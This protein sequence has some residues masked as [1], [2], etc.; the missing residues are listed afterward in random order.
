[1]YRFIFLLFL[2]G[3]NFS[4]KKVETIA[5]AL[6]NKFQVSDIYI[7]FNQ[8][9]TVGDLKLINGKHFFFVNKSEEIFGLESNVKDSYIEYYIVENN[10]FKRVYYPS[11]IRIQ[12]IPDSVFLVVGGSLRTLV[13]DNEKEP[14]E[15]KYITFR[16]NFAADLKKNW[17]IPD[18]IVVKKFN[19]FLFLE[20]KE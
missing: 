6:A 16:A 4:E 2:L 1:M 7:F 9:S 13:L 10:E 8:S 19:S 20:K 17:E 15:V 18:S 14:L 11:E 3:C 12:E 5:I